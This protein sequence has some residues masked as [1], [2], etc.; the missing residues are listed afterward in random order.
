MNNIGIGMTVVHSGIA[1]N[2]VIDSFDK[3]LGVINLTPPAGTDSAVTGT[4]SNQSMT[5]NRVLGQ[6][7]SPVSYTH[8]TLP[9]ICSV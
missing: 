1:T 8:L 4:I 2:T 5:F 7:V 3:T 6:S 9:T